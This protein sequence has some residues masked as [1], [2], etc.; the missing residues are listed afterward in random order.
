MTPPFNRSRMSVP[1]S[2]VAYS[3]EQAL[4]DSNQPLSKLRQQA[5]MYLS[6]YLTHDAI[7]KRGDFPS[8]EVFQH[9]FKVLTDAL[10]D[11]NTSIV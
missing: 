7:R 8:K 6:K 5:F 11:S 2:P 1:Q 3:L 4:K 10:S 9:I